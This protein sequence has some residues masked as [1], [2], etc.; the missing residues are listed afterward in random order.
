MIITLELLES[1]GWDIEHD[2]VA[3]TQPVLPSCSAYFDNVD[4]LMEEASVYF[5]LNAN[6]KLNNGIYTD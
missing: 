5:N 1:D 2:L 4:K 6:K 3:H